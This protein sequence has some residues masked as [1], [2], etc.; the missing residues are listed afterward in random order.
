MRIIDFCRGGTTRRGLCTHCGRNC[1]GPTSASSSPSTTP[2][3]DFY[4]E[5]C[6]IERWSTRSLKSKTDGMLFERT[7][8]AKRPTRVV[9]PRCPDGELTAGPRFEADKDAWFDMDLRTETA[10]VVL[11]RRDFVS[12]GLLSPLHQDSSMARERGDC[13]SGRMRAQQKGLYFATLALVLSSLLQ[14]GGVSTENV[15]G[16]EATPGG[17]SP[18]DSRRLA[19]AQCNYL[20]RCEPDTI[21]FFPRDLWEACRDHFVCSAE[22][23]L[24][25]WLRA[26]DPPNVDLESCIES[27]AAKPCPNLDEDPFAVFKGYSFPWTE[28]C[29]APD[30]S[31]GLEP[32]PDAPM[33]GEICLIEAGT[34]RPDCQGDTYC[35]PSSDLPDFG[36]YRCGRCMVRVA[37]GQSCDTDTRC[38][39]GARCILGQCATPRAVGESCT[40]DEQCL[41]RR[42]EAGACARS[43][44]AP[45]LYGE[46]FGQPCEGGSGYCGSAV[47]LTCVEGSCQPLSDEGEPCVPNV[48]Y[49]SCRT[50]QLCIDGRCVTVGCSLDLYEPCVGG[51][52]TGEC[53]EGICVPLGSRVGDACQLFCTNSLVC[54]DHLCDARPD[55]GLGAPCDFDRDCASGYC[56]RDLTAYCED[57]NCSIPPCGRCGVCATPPTVASCL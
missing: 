23:G 10:S 57:G 11:S 20:E 36:L 38:T 3:R 14:C 13:Y 25:P 7:A 32:L 46:V 15:S 19:Q 5:L 48:T 39:M 24:V 8:I 49:L 54:V 44:Y 52:T 40:E 2:K 41:F 53:I 35:E 51:C 27:I 37:L 1:S 16:N 17:L 12:P 18:V 50:G 56:Q 34:E 6:R 4:T 43:E 28:E 47:P 9:E 30:L 45:R 55:S 21:H 33:Q 31:A 42:C 26:V 22:H 29:G